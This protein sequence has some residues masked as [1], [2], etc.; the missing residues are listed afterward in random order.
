MAYNDR[1]DRSRERERG[2]SMTATIL[3]EVRFAGGRRFQAVLG[4]LLREPADGIV[5]AANGALMHGGGVAAAIARAAGSALE[6]EGD[7][8]VAGHGP[9]PTGGAV[10]TTAGNLPFKGVIHAV[11][12]RQG[13]G[14]ERE[15]LER[16]LFSAFLIADEKGWV[17]LSFPAVS[18]GIFAVP[19]PV[20][21]RAYAAAVARFFEDR[22]D[23]SLKLIRLVL[24]PGP[25]V[26][27][28][29]TAMDDLR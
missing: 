18:S 10:A 29:T 8:F 2:L 13:E 14:D 28:V 24:C 17:S 19:A 5:N 20:C 12:P 15:K 22:P 4:D 23:S 9:I 21:A 26:D 7:R 11:G 25:L 16:A 1:L 6:E 27:E 3:T